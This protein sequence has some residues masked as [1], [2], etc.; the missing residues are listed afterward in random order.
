ML[1]T[2]WLSEIGSTLE[3]WGRCVCGGW[4]GG[5]GGGGGGGK[6]FASRGGVKGTEVKWKRNKL[7]K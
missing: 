5:G 1:R 7:R 4:G 6:Y 2:L 3:G